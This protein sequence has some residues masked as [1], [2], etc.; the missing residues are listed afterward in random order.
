LIKTRVYDLVRKGVLRRADNSAGVVLA[1]AAGKAV[2]AKTST[3][4]QKN[5]KKATAGKPSASTASAQPA[6]WRSLHEVLT[7]VLA[8]SS[9]PLSAQELADKVIESGYESKSKDFKNVIWV[10]IGKLASAERVPGEGYRLKKGKA[11]GSG[12]KP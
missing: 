5:G 1:K 12:K 3:V 8:Q 9:R 2:E 4:T 7:H 10:S 6:K 11:S